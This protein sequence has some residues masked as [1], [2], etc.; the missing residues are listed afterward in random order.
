[1]PALSRGHAREL[2]PLT[3]VLARVHQTIQ[4][5]APS[6]RLARPMVPRVT[7][8]AQ[9][10]QHTQAP[11]PGSHIHARRAIQTRRELRVHH[12]A[13]ARASGAREER[14]RQVV[15]LHN[16]QLQYFHRKGAQVRTESVVV[17]VSRKEAEIREVFGHAALGGTRARG[18]SPFQPLLSRPYAVVAVRTRRS[19]VVPHPVPAVLTNHSASIQHAPLAAGRSWFVIAPQGR[20]AHRREERAG[21]SRARD[22]PSTRR[23]RLR[24]CHRR[25]A[26]SVVRRGRTT[27]ARDEV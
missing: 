2:V 20:S 23:A 16:D 11:L 3:P 21:P 7:F 12:R 9:V 22:G 10:S 6:C 13:Q 5:P 18:P 19:P 25:L 17:R 1:M 4:V 27:A 26:V 14:A 8:A 24:G 15:E